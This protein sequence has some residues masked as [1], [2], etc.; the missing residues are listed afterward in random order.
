V[1][2]ATCAVLIATQAGFAAGLL[3]AAAALVVAAVMIP[4]WRPIVG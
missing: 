4:A 1:V 3:S 2:G